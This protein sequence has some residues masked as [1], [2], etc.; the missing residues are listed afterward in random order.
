MEGAGTRGGENAGDCDE[1]LDG[2]REKQPQGDE[3][4]KNDVQISTDSPFVD[5]N[6][7]F[8]IEIEEVQSDDGGNSVEPA[9]GG[10]RRRL[11]LGAISRIVLEPE[12]PER[13]QPKTKMK[14]NKQGPG[15]EFS[16]SSKLGDKSKS[17]NKDDKNPS[18]SKPKKSFGQLISS[19]RGQFW[20]TADVFRDVNPESYVIFSMRD[21]V[22]YLLFLVLTATIAFGSLAYAYN[23]YANVLSELLTNSKFPTPIGVFKTFK[24]IHSIQDIWLYLN[25][26][27]LA[28][29]YPDLTIGGNRTASLEDPVTQFEGI[30]VLQENILVGAPQLRQVRVKSGTCYP[31]VMFKDVYVSCFDYF[32]DEIQ[33]KD[34]F[35]EASSEPFQ[36]SPPTGVN[37]HHSGHVSTYGQGGFVMNFTR[38]LNFTRASLQD[39]SNNV[40]LRA[41]SR[42][43]FLDFTLYT[44]NANLFCVVKLVFEI[45][46]SGG[47]VT[48]SHIYAL[49]LLRYVA[50]WDYFIFG[51]EII[52][53]LFAIYYLIEEINQIVI[54]KEY[55]L[56]NWWNILDLII[57]LF[58]WAVVLLGIARYIAISGS[59]ES[60]VETIH[61][62]NY[63]SFEFFTRIQNAF[64]VTAS[65]LTF[66]VWIKLVKFSSLNRSVSLIISTFGRVKLELVSLVLMM[67]AVV[68]GFALLGNAIFGSKVVQFRSVNDSFFTLIGLFIGGLYFYEDCQNADRISSQIFFVLYI[69]FVLVIFLSAF[70]A[71]IVY[72]FHKAVNEI[73]DVRDR[74]YLGDVCNQLFLKLLTVLRRKKLAGKL[75]A[76]QLAKLYERDYDA[77]LNIIRRHGYR[78]LDLALLLKKHNVKP[79][80]PISL[81]TMSDVYND[82]TTRNQLHM[83]VEEHDK[84]MEHID[85]INKTIEF[86][87]LTL[88]DIVAKV[89]I[90]ANRLVD[91]P[92]PRR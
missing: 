78:G 49:K 10:S 84:I 26:T 27:V 3:G 89:D 46:P 24:D 8:E 7:P 39:L 16:S 19:A 64:N 69:F 58:S 60:K 1:D 14:T 22:L 57:V 23:Y 2:Q 30:R 87:D 50:K 80:Q 76:R 79:G 42:A 92:A 41:G 6:E 70:V 21:F 90:L 9:A 53:T 55:Y 65:I 83:E 5:W 63:A 48:S 29:L 62:N 43:V 45:I 20:N 18:E 12:E 17:A 32:D 51:C 91:R 68:M 36:Y 74:V 13:H 47:V 61:T 44:A 4:S 75:R 71:L 52:F 11:N 67:T 88:A 81:N 25:T 37:L 31:A 40:W 66:L 15:K 54:L 35:G 86:L 72:G 59:M 56:T 77:L 85:K 73:D 33:D 82:L 28:V 38:D 34:N